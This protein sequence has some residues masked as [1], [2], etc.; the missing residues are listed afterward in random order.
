MRASPAAVEDEMFQLSEAGSQ[1]VAH[2]RRC[3]S[4]FAGAFSIA[5]TFLRGIRY[6]SKKDFA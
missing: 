4:S 3:S 1:L 6:G 5:Q 2:R